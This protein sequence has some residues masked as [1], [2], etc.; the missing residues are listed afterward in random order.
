MY[1]VHVRDVPLVVVCGTRKGRSKINEHYL[2]HTNAV[3]DF[4]KHVY[5]WNISALFE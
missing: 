1:T 4:T 5:F 2:Y 3:T